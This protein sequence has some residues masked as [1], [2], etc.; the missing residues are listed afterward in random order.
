[1]ERDIVEL[2]KE[3]WAVAV[4][5]VGLIV[6]AV[7]VEAGMKQNSS[8]IRGLWRQRNEDIEAHRQ[9]RIETNALIQ[10]VDQ[11]IDAGFTELRGD[12]KTL[13]QRKGG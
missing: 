2:I 1:M 9:A 11:K 4:G 5:F 10:K 6:W 12:I 3:Y 13:L 8:D 7:R